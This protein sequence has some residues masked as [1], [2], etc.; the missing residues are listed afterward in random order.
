MCDVLQEFLDT[1]SSPNLD[2]PLNAEIAKLYSEDKKAFIS[3]VKAHVT[4]HSLRR[5]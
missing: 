4:K 1:M 2:S 3:T 5:A